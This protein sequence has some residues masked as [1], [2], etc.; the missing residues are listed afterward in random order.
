MSEVLT[1]NTIAASSCANFLTRMMRFLKTFAWAAL[2]ASAV[3]VSLGFSLIGPNN[4]PYQVPDLGYNPVGRD[5]LPIAPK[6]LGEEYRRNTPVMYYSFDANFLDY[7]GSNGVYAVDQAFGV[8]NSL[9]NFSSYSCD[10]SEFAFNSVRQNFLAES[11][12]MID[13]KAF[14]MNLIIENLGLAQPE[15]YIFAEKNRVLLPG[16]TC[17]PNML[18]LI[19]KRNFNPFTCAVDQTQSK[20]TSY[21]NVIQ[22]TGVLALSLVNCASKWVEISFD[23]QVQHVRRTS[24]SREEDAIL[25][26]E[27]ITLG[28]GQTQILD[29]EVHGE[30]LQVDHEEAFGEEVLAHAVKSKFAEIAGVGRKIG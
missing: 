20:Y 30:G 5:P 25:F 8:F 19:I 4:E 16:G 23:Y 21:L 22:I 10:L 14:T 6:N 15:R 2:L 18:Y 24:S 11:L 9:T 28:L 12:L 27:N 29:N 26:C 7:F 13:L 1:L 3:N 17:P